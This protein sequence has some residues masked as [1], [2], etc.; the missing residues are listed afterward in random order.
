MLNRYSFIGN[1]GKDAEIRTL[2]SGASAISFTV[3]VTEKWKN[4]NGEAMENT[5]WVAC[6]I[7]KAAGVSTAIAQYLKKGTRV[8]VDGKP[9]ARAYVKGDGTAAAS[10]EVR[11]DDLT[12]LNALQ[13][14]QAQPAQQQYQ[15]LTQQQ[16][17]QQNAGY[18]AAGQN[19][20]SFGGTTEIVDDLPF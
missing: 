6:T 4:R 14:G 13:N 16:I 12:L 10:L 17:A 2:E 18:Q 20:G 7:W 19:L 1:L 15:P 5:T 8:H 3:A 9:S 11:V